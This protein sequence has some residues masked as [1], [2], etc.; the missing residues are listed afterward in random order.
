MVEG[1]AGPVRGTVRV[2]DD[3]AQVAGRNAGLEDQGS[4][5]LG[6]AF[7]VVEDGEGPVA[8]VFQGGGDED[9]LG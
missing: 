8:A 3:G 4:V 1:E 6:D 9:A 5:R 2:V 7:S